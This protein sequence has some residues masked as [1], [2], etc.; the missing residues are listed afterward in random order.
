[1]AEA[2]ELTL[3][4]DLLAAVMAG[5]AVEPLD[6]GRRVSCG[7]RRRPSACLRASCGLPAGFLRA[8]AEA[9]LGALWPVNDLS[10]ALVMIAS[11]ASCSRPPARMRAA[12]RPPPS[13]RPDDV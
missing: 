2:A 9:V 12:R 10:T 4:S 11:A 1:M 3:L 7:R 6:P 8:G 13:W 5:E